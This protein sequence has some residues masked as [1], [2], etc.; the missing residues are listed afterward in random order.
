M[1]R[2]LAYE[3]TL[4]AEAQRVLSE[5]AAARR[6]MAGHVK[7]ENIYT[8][9]SVGGEYAQTLAELRDATREHLAK[10]KRIR[11][12]E[13]RLQRERAW[14]AQAVLLDPDSPMGKQTRG[15]QDTDLVWMC[16]GTSS[17]FWPAIRRDG[18]VPTEASHRRTW[19]G[20]TPSTLGYVYLT[21]ACNQGGRG[22]ARFYA[23][24][25]AGT[26]G[27]DPIA[28][29]LVVP[30]GW[31]EPDDDDADLAT[32]RVQFRTAHRIQ[33]DLLRE[34]DGRRIHLP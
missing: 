21:A 18:L 31:L 27:G 4:P 15:L 23:Q 17:K 7:W 1:P 16:H 24:I 26:W 30:W 11:A 2:D 3:A 29:R 25:A 6:G 12:G 10:A 22:D 28:L 34:K 5:F 8:Y 14:D 19:K 13:R 32:G 9:L 33:P 20:T